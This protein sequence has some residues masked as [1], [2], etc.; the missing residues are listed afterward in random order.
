M[1]LGIQVAG[2]CFGLFM[3]YYSFLHY[4][5]KEFTIKEFSFWLVLWTAFSFV[6]LFPQSLDFFVER[7]NLNR[8]MD[9][10]TIAGFMTLLAIF[11]YTYSLVRQNQRKLEM[12]VRKFAKEKR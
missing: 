1:V 10:F 8:T 12:I 5:R 11:I 7:L 2:L 3:I 6:S 4:K 9:L